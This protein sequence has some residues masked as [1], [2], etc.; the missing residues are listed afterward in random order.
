[1]VEWKRL[2]FNELEVYLEKGSEM[3]DKNM[4]SRLQLSV[5]MILVI[6]LLLMGIVMDNE[7]NNIA[8]IMI[9]YLPAIIYNLF[10]AFKRSNNKI[11]IFNFIFTLAIVIFAWF[12]R[13]ILY[14]LAHD[15]HANISFAHITFGIVAILV[16]LLFAL[17]F[18]SR[19]R[20]EAI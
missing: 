17:E 3:K 5:A 13:N 4:V 11:N 19:K 12:V 20:Y 14:V 15:W 10:A 2:Y 16:C 18:S 8:V 1:V 6:H 9:I 7:W